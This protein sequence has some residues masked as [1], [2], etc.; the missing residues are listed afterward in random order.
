MHLNETK[1]RSSFQSERRFSQLTKER[2][3][4]KMNIEAACGHCVSDAPLRSAAFLVT[5]GA[6]AF[7]PMTVFESQSMVL[8]VREGGRSKR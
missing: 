6:L 5:F 3:G 7:W 4:G 8:I 1:F 2:K